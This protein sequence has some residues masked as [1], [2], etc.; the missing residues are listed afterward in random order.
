MCNAQ[1]TGT[2]VETKTKKRLRNKGF[3]DVA[4]WLLK[5]PATCQCISGTDLLG[6]CC[7]TETEVADQSFYLTRSQH[8]DTRP[9]SAD[10]TTPGAWQGSHWSANFEVTVIIRPGIIPTP[11]AGIEPRTLRSRGGHPDHQA[12]EAV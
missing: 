4:F 12:N 3:V 9:T 2:V 11:Q 6:Q 10:P 8:T 7:H 5:V 1:P